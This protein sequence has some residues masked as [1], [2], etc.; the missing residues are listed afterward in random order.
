MKKTFAQWMRE[1]DAILENKCGLSHQDLPDIPYRD[2]YDAG[3]GPKAAAN[4]AWKCA[5]GEM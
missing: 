3:K 4:R 1:V 5:K 2:M